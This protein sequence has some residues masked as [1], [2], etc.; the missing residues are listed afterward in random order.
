MNS[1]RSSI[2]IRQLISTRLP[3]RNK[4]EIV[5]AYRNNRITLREAAKLLSVDYWEVQDILA[6]E[7]IPISNLTESEIKSR[8][9]KIK[10]DAF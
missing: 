2:A 3:E 9:K 7:G 8:T 10:K 5:E 1:P 4:K 6:E